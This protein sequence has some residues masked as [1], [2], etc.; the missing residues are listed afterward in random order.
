MRRGSDLD[1]GKLNATAYTHTHRRGDKDDSEGRREANVT[2][3]GGERGHPGSS[4]HH[5]IAP[6][7]IARVPITMQ[8]IN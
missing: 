2:E 8:S 7:K 4:L 3:G 5:S 1:L 6:E